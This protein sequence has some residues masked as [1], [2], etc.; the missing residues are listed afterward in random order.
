MLLQQTAVLARDA[1]VLREGVEDLERGAR[2][3]GGAVG[4]REVDPEALRHVALL[5][6]VPVFPLL[7]AAHLPGRIKQAAK[8][9]MLLAVKIWAFTHLLANG[10][11]GSILLFGGL[12]AW[13]VYDRISLKRRGDAGAPQV[14]WS[15]NDVL[16]LV[17]GT[18]A[19]FL[20]FWLHDSLIGVTAA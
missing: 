13:A 5:L 6:M 11:L 16:V 8:H 17:L 4:V 14:G 1:R 15:G 2:I 9:P 20:M 3:V 7:F 12:L 10:D 18:A 19:Y